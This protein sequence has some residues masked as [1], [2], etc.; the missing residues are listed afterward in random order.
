MVYL[1][2]ACLAAGL[3]VAQK[4]HSLFCAI[5]S[6]IHLFTVLCAGR[7]ASALTSHFSRYR[8]F[9]FGLSGFRFLGGF[10]LSVRVFLAPAAQRGLCP[11]ALRA[12]L[13]KGSSPLG[14]LASLARLDP[15][16]V[17]QSAAFFICT[18]R[19]TPYIK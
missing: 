13:P 18:N 1:A 12:P 6:A 2:P 19:F 8:R 14:I 10:V 15:L 7:F 9:N 17:L 11:H 16:S 3:W 4:S 5:K